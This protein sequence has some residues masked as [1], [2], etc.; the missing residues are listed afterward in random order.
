MLL[1]IFSC[2]AV[3]LKSAGARGRAPV[4][5]IVIGFQFFGKMQALRVPKMLGYPLVVSVVDLTDGQIS[6]GVG[7]FL[8]G[9]HRLHM[10]SS[11][12]YAVVV[13]VHRC[14]DRKSVTWSAGLPFRL[15]G[16]GVL[17][18]RHGEFEH[19]PCLC[20]ADGSSPSFPHGAVAPCW[21][22]VSLMAV[23]V[24]WPTRSVAS[25]IGCCEARLGAVQLGQCR[26]WCVRAWDVWPQ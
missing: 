18:L 1:L 24:G 5:R 14:R 22:L 2:E 16:A 25:R 10:G 9:G 26:C 12:P 4:W 11:F 19:L 8:G 6:G 15:P 23:P 13:S 20:C 7:V 17:L 3:A 21:F